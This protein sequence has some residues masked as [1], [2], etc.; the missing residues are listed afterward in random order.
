M[1]G[2]LGARPDAATTIDRHRIVDRDSLGEAHQVAAV[3]EM[4][5]AGVMLRMWTISIVA[6]VPFRYGLMSRR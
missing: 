3:A 6:G 5:Q 1:L 4:T 2:D